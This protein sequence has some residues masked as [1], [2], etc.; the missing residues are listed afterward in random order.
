ML[1]L[2]GL[3]HKRVSNVA[4]VHLDFP[5]IYMGPT[6]KILSIPVYFFKYH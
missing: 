1:L 4:P 6:D 3:M 5:L 2:Q